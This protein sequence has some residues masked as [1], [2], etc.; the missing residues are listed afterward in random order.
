M[1]ATI[2][3]HKEGHEGTITVD[4]RTGVVV[5]D[6][7]ERP[8]WAHGLTCA[9]LAERVG[10]YRTKLGPLADPIVSPIAIEKTDLGW[11]LLREDGEEEMIPADADTRIA[12]ISEV[13]EAE[14]DPGVE[15]EI[16][17]AHTADADVE[18]AGG[19]HPFNAIAADA[20]GL[21]TLD[22]VAASRGG[23]PVRAVR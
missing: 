19:P 8:E 23:D 15:V 10:Y 18:M 3:V 20:L 2:T 1:N 21:P 14:R 16:E 7:T 9:L 5:G 22:E 13:L 11:V 12:V 6:V 17:M 4:A